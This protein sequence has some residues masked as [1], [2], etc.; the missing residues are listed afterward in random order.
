MEEASN[1]FETT[2]AVHTFAAPGTQ[3]IEQVLER[4]GGAGCSDSA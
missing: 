3:A 1:R 4:V 2:F